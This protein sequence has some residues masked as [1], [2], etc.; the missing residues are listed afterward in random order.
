MVSEKAC[1][2]S[3]TDCLL[4]AVVI[5]LIEADGS[6]RPLAGLGGTRQ[7]PFHALIDSFFL[8]VTSSISFFRHALVSADRCHVCLFRL[9]LYSCLVT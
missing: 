1:E 7:C 3:L 6:A 4:L 2:G 9:F 5:A 8:L